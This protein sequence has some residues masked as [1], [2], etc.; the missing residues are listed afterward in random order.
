[1]PENIELQPQLYTGDIRDIAA[2]TTEHARASR[3]IN[4][5]RK[6]ADNP[7]VFQ[8]AFT[9]LGTSATSGSHE[10]H[11]EDNLTRS[12]VRKPEKLIEEYFTKR[13][14]LETEFDEA[15]DEAIYTS[16][17]FKKLQE[18]VNKKKSITR[19]VG[20]MKSEIVPNA[21]AEPAR[22]AVRRYIFGEYL[23]RAVMW[24]EQNTQKG[25][26]RAV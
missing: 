18:T 21:E 19:R 17:E 1:M 10:L 25:Q 12:A 9:T 15:T 23:G 20:A 24:S 6:I 13:D 16:P 7:Q 8:D 4:L 5:Q 11:D 26:R 2:G 14:D 22:N 3:L